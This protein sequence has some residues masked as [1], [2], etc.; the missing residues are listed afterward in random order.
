MWDLAR[1]PWN[2]Q[3]FFLKLTPNWP[4]LLAYLLIIAFPIWRQRRH[5][6][7]RSFLLGNGSL[8]FPRIIVANKNKCVP[9]I[10]TGFF[11]FL[12]PLLANIMS[13]TKFWWVKLAWLGLD[14]NMPCFPPD[15]STF[16]RN[17]TVLRII[18]ARHAAAT[19]ARK[20]VLYP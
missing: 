7:F 13:L 19:E 2:Q 12:L 14:E 8:G 3:S 18:R 1:P 16:P 10:M 6:L 9:A 4:C 11:L 17:E 15:S 20:S 5:L